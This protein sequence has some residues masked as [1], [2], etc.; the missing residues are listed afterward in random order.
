M[1]GRKAIVQNVEPG[2]RKKKL[3]ETNIKGALAGRVRA[4]GKRRLQLVASEKKTF[5]RAQLVEAAVAL[6]LDLE[7]DKDWNEMAFE[8]GIPLIALKT[9]T[10]TDEFMEC[11]SEHFAELGHD[12]RLRATQA[13][14]VDMLPQ[15]VRELRELLSCNSPSVKLSAIKEIIRLNGIDQPKTAANDRSELAE[16]LKNAGVNLTQVNQITVPPEYAQAVRDTIDATF[17]TPHD[18]VQDADAATE[19][20]VEP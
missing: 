2:V 18:V 15:A 5:K 20:V 14:L 10:K 11:Y 9:L 8:L 12:P 17:S 19:V 16:F 1:Q 3:D 13:A 7:H 4:D 6:F